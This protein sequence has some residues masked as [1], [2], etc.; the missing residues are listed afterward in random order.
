MYRLS[1]GTYILSGENRD[2]HFFQT[3][4]NPKKDTACNELAPMLGEGGSDRSKDGENRANKDGSASTKPIVYG[5]GDPGGAFQVR[6][7]SLQADFCIHT[8]YK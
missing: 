4:A 2:G 6:F 1:P 3:H 7:V 5:I 8:R